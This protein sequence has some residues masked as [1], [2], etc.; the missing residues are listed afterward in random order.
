MP[1]YG[2]PSRITPDFLYHLARMG[3]GDRVVV[4]DAN[5]PSD[6]IATSCVVKEVIRVSGSTA[7]VLNDIL[8]LFPLDTYDPERLQVMDKVD[9]DKARNL[10][11]VAYQCIADAANYKVDSLTYVERFE[12]YE[13]AKRAFFIVQTDESSLYANVIVSKGVLVASA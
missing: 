11:V 12:F 13:R 10:P 6:S 1:L 9:A 4:A 7:E 8:K 3:H 5:F 2:V